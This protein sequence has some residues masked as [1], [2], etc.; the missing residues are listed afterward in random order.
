MVKGILFPGVCA[1]AIVMLNSPSAIAQQ[2]KPLPATPVIA[3][4]IDPASLNAP[5]AFGDSAPVEK[6]PVEPPTL[7][8][9]PL[10]SLAAAE[11]VWKPKLR[12]VLETKSGTLDKP[13]PYHRSAAPGAFETD[14]P[15]PL[16]N[17]A[18]RAPNKI[19]ALVQPFATLMCDEV[20]VDAKASET[21][22]LAYSVSCK[23]KV[24]LKIDD[25][26]VTGDSISSVEGK[27]TI[28][29]AV[30]K[31]NKAT[32]TAEKM[33]IQL[34]IFGVHVERNSG[35]LGG[36]GDSLDP[37]PDPIDAPI[38]DPSHFRSS[39]QLERN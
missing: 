27:L 24:M 3:N 8:P 6:K 23:G 38:D 18:K 33:Q 9:E 35:E 26:T 30:V 1:F 36:S 32:L 7:Q 2:P 29:N 13:T 25:Y 31:S 11:T 19:V 12:V 10:E 20:T 17:A 16:P 39:A 37:I 5:P 28:T 34:P 21:G 4:P 14:E 22:E 15:V